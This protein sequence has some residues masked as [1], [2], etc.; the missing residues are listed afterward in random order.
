MNWGVLLFFAAW[1]LGFVGL[2][3]LLRKVFGWVVLAK[4]N[5]IEDVD[6]VGYTR[7]FS[8]FGVSCGG[9]VY[10]TIGGLCRITVGDR[11]ILVRCYPP[12]SWFLPP[13]LIKWQDISKYAWEE[14]IGSRLVIHH[15]SGQFRFAVAGAVAH[16][17]EERASLMI[18]QSQR[19]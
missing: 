4:R 1:L 7:H 9:M 15:V 11:G 19:D 16:K 10:G 2:L 5:D 18:E 12:I 14:N 8:S 6:G 17:F 13:I 3:F